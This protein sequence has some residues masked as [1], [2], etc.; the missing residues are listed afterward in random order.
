MPHFAEGTGLPIGEIQA[1]SRNDEAAKTNAPDAIHTKNR[2][3]TYL[4]KHPEYFGPQLE[5]AGVPQP[6][7]HKKG[8]SVQLTSLSQ[9][10]YST[11]A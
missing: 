9:I 3:K 11:T 10:H 1:M 8:R 6:L 2:R 4:D 5:L 7:A